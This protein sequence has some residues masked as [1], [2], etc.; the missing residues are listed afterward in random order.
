M[1]VGQLKYSADASSRISDAGSSMPAGPGSLPLITRSH[2]SRSVTAGV[3]QSSQSRPRKLSVSVMWLVCQVWEFVWS[4]GL[5]FQVTV[6][7]PQK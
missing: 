2:S 1:T 4:L 7:N 6:Y 5:T 3:H